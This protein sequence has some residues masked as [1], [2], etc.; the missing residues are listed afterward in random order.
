M[1]SHIFGVDKYGYQVDHFS[2]NTIDEIQLL[3]TTNYKK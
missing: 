2:K 3:L 1:L